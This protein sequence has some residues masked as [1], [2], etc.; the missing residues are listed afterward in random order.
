[1]SK[2]ERGWGPASMKKRWHPAGGLS[3]FA[4]AVAL[5]VL[6]ADAAPSVRA[7]EPDQARGT[8]PGQAHGRLFPPQDLG[9]LEGPDRDAWQKPDEVM[10]ALGIADGAA[11]ADLGAGGGWFTIRLARR[12]GPNGVV[13]AEDVQPEMIESITRRVEREGL[14]NV[15]P[16]LGAPTNPRLP[17]AALDA[18]LIVGVYHEMEDPV[19]LL[20]NVAAALKPRGRIGIIDF[21]REGFGPGPPMEERVD[22]ERIITDARAAGLALSAREDFLRYQYLLVFTR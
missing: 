22:P 12:V 15:K 10:D 1:L 6:A 13:Y 20:K 14:P 19:A 3:G 7:A 21:T 8:K 16:I 5:A 4:A 2:D 17:E 18:V 11:V 9:L